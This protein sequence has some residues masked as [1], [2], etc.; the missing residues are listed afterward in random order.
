MCLQVPPDAATQ[1][2][3][4]QAVGA[5]AIHKVVQLATLG[6]KHANIF[7]P[8]PSIITMTMISG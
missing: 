1:M 6:T 5:N 8:P 4:S 7:C 2:L 3:V